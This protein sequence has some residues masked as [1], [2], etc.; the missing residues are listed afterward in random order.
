MHPHPPFND[1]SCSLCAGTGHVVTR[2]QVEDL[3]G[4]LRLKSYSSTA[5]LTV[6]ALGLLVAAPLVSWWLLI[7]LAFTAPVLA[8]L[9]FQ[10]SQISG[11]QMYSILQ[12]APARDDP[13][14][15]WVR[16]KATP[17]DEMNPPL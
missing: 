16:I 6:L 4:E 15:R 12:A 2:F 1:V 7:M 9:A 3:G 11:P 17:I 8:I 14:A 10:C 5:A 13:P